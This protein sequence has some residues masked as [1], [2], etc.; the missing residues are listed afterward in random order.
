MALEKYVYPATVSPEPSGLYSIWFD[1][2]DCCA[3][4]GDSIIDALDAAA[5]VLAGWIYA[6]QKQNYPIPA[7]SSIDDV[8]HAPGQFVT[9][10]V[11]DVEAYRRL[12]DSYAVKKT[13]T[14]PN[15]LNEKAEAAN[16]NYSKIL[17]DALM[18]YL[19]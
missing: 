7:P 3:T 4:Q 16:V 1:D 10:I 6:A 5:D 19:G 9:Y 13:L 12:N 2:L 11:A 18:Q 14:I 8:K 17:Q 15:W